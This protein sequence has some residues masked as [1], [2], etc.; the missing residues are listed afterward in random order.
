MTNKIETAGK[1]PEKEENLLMRLASDPRASFLLL[2]FVPLVLPAITG[3]T[4]MFT[5]EGQDIFTGAMLSLFMLSAT[6]LGGFSLLYGFQAKINPSTMVFPGIGIFLTI[7]FCVRFAGGTL[8]MISALPPGT[9]ILA[10]EL[11]PK[12][13]IP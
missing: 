6:V 4:G 10:D 5:L 7:Y 13:I 9:S 1:I 3:N 2:I 11:G 12:L 8:E